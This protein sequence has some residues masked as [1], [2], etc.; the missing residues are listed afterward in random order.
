[1][2]TERTI[3]KVSKPAICCNVKTQMGYGTCQ[4]KGAYIVSGLRGHFCTQHAKGF[5]VGNTYPTH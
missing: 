3:I 4:R 1:M 2:R 5:A